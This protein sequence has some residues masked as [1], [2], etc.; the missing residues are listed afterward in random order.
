MFYFAKFTN[1]P[2]TPN[3][4]RIKQKR[5]KEVPKHTSTDWNKNRK[6]SQEQR[7]E[8]RQHDRRFT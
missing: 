4:D 2:L 7:I 6:D 8:W 1:R 5:R 3:K